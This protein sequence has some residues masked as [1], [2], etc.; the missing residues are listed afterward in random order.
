MRQTKLIT[1][2]PLLAAMSAAIAVAQIPETYQKLWSEPGLQEQMRSNIERYRKGEAT[3]QVAD[4]SGKP[5]ADATI[6]VRQQTHEFLFGCNLFVLDQFATPELNGRY[7]SAFTNIFNFAT[8]PFYWGD[9]EP[10]KGKPRYGEDSPY[11]WRR[12]PTDRMVKWCLANGITPKGHAFLYVKNMFMPEWTARK[13]PEALRRQ[14]AKHIAELAKRYGR[15]IPIWD[16]VNEEIPRMRH[17]DEWPAVPSDFVPWSFREAARRLPESAMLILN[18]GTH[19]A[20]DTTAEYESLIKGALDQ[21]APVR[22]IGIQ[23]H[24]YN[25][26]GM[27]NGKSLPPAQLAAVYERLG[28]LGLPLYITEITVPGKEENG[29]ALQ[30][31]IV[32]NLYRLWFSTPKMAGIT[33]WNLCDGGAFQ[34]ENK[35][36]GGLIDQDMKPKPAY[37]ALDQLINREWKTTL[38]LKTDSNGKATFRG[39]YGKYAVECTTGSGSKTGFS[40]DLNHAAAAQPVKFKVR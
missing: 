5:L 6:V 15:Q 21:G 4:R 35:A 7:K 40:M 16:V 18:D 38:T 34:E 39:F 9:L 19:E 13:D 17:P 28:R 1:L 31:E 27:L 26:A 37:Q 12:P 22:G 36:L 10:V 24:V 33:W 25:R 8:V 29:A 11:I 30:A 32:A 3:I 23:F 2:V 14:S 20:H